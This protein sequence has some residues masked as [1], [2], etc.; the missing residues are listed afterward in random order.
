MENF[1]AAMENTLAQMIFCLNENQLIT[2][3]GLMH[4]FT[5]TNDIKASIDDKLK[6]ETREGLFYQLTAIQEKR[7]KQGRTAFLF[8]MSPSYRLFDTVADSDGGISCDVYMYE[9]HHSGDNNNDVCQLRIMRLDISFTRQRDL[10]KICEFHLYTIQTMKAWNF[11]ADRNGAP[12]APFVNTAFCERPELTSGA[13]SAYAEVKKMVNMLWDRLMCSIDHLFSDKAVCDKIKQ[14]FR[15]ENNME[16][17]IGLTASPQIFREENGVMNVLYPVE[18]FK[19]KHISKTSSTVERT[20]HYVKLCISCENG[21]WKIQDAQ[22]LPVF[23]LPLLPY[24]SG[25]R[26]DKISNDIIPWKLY[27]TATPYM[28][29][30]DAYEIENILS[31]WIYSARRGKLWPFYKKYMENDSFVPKMMMKSYGN[32]SPVHIGRSGIQK[33]LEDLESHYIPGMFSYHMAT[34]PVIQFSED[35][36]T[37]WG[38]WFDHSA[39]NLYDAAVC[40]DVIPYMIFVGRYMHEF[41]KIQNQWYMTSFFGEPLLSMADWEFDVPASEGWVKTRKGEHYP[42]LFASLSL[43]NI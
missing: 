8:T 38:A 19:L 6:A 32:Q 16:P 24:I 25:K 9:N 13:L 2:D 28:Y 37:A 33:K 4:L 23:A 5:E 43:N 34:T 11:D 15:S 12:M 30:E 1:Y 39:T 26:Y 17:S 40:K 41:K 7:A 22:M 42:K 3:N 10:A 18:L 35:G 20:F 36:K 21:S 31:Q 27:N 29:P 14:Y